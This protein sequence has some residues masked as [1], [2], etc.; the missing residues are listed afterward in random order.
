M[1]QDGISVRVTFFQCE[2]SMPDGSLLLPRSYCL[3]R[4][5]RGHIDGPATVSRDSHG[6]S[7]HTTCPAMQR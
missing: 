6:P 2:S 4:W 5:D 3:G 7:R 1:S